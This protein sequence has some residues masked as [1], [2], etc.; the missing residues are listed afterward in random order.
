M[1]ETVKE[2]RAAGGKAHGYIVDV[3]KREKIY[4]AADKV[5]AEVGKVDILINNAGIVSGSRFLE[6]SDEKIDR[7]MQVNSMANFWV[8]FSI[9]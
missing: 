7:T 2:I 8:C 1:E 4:E 9:Q 6:T 5:K 3:T